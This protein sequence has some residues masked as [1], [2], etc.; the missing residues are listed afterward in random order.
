MECIN[1]KKDGYYFNETTKYYELCDEQCET[2]NS[3][4]TELSSNC[5][6]CKNNEKKIIKI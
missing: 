1:N 5:L 3:S 2:C 4:P 6:T